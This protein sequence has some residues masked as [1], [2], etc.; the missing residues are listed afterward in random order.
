MKKELSNK[1]LT[2]PE[3]QTERQK[4]KRRSKTLT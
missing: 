4:K 3:G 2:Y 1:C